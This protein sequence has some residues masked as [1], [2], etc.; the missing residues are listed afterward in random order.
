[1]LVEG[2]YLTW[3][4]LKKGRVIYRHSVQATGPSSSYLSERS[5]EIPGLVLSYYFIKTHKHPF[6]RDCRDK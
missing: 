6:F 5:K 2:V 3:L 4:K 1:M